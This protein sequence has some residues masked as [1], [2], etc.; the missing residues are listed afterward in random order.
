M[1]EGHSGIINFFSEVDHEHFQLAN[2]IANNILFLIVYHEMGHI[3]S[4]H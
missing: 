1:Y 4:G 2:N 3:I